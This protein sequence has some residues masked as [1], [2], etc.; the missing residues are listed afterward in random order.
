MILLAAFAGLR[1]HEIAKV[2]GDHLDLIGRQFVVTGKGAVTA[3]LPLHHMLIEQAYRMPR[4][5][6][7]FPGPDHGHQRRE[8]IGGTIK[9]AMIRAGV[10]GSAHQ[11]RHWFLSELVETGTDLRTVQDLGR[12]AD[13]SSTAIY[14]QV[15]DRRRAEGVD[16]L[17]PWR[18]D[19]SNT[20][21]KIATA[22][23]R[24]PTLNPA[25]VLAEL[26]ALGAA[27]VIRNGNDVA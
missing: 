18:A 8:S 12:H 23:Q 19:P 14:T 3:T 27:T 5:G 2:R 4:E 1:V 11:L 9:E 17:N 13:L 26:T 10:A 16:R 20:A 25:A 15:T 6:W 7:W 21:A 24:R 22:V